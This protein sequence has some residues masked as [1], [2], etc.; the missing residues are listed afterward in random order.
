MIR[1]Q[2]YLPERLYHTITTVAKQEKKPKA[3]VIRELLETGLETRR[4]PATIGKALLH[5]TQVKAHAPEDT[6]MKIDDYLYNR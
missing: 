4:K 6:S 2:V 1:T 5:L 3:E